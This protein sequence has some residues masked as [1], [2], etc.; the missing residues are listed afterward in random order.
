MDA[1]V[2]VSFDPETVTQFRL[3]GF[4]NRQLDHDDLRDDSVDGGEVGAGHNVTALYEVTVPN[5][6]SV[7]ADTELATVVLV[8][9]DPDSGEPVE[10]SATITAGD[11]TGSFEAAPLRLRQDILVAAFAEQLRDAPW[12]DLIDLP[13]LVTKTDALHRSAEGDEYLAELVELVQLAANL[14]T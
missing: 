12:A 4:E 11:V 6:G 7:S 14:G 1:K 2:Q 13:Q 3:L 10:T 8:W 9:R 5:I